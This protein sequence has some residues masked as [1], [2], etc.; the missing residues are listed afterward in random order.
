MDL[1]MELLKIFNEHR[2]YIKEDLFIEPYGIHG[3][4][5]AERVMFLALNIA[6]LEKYDDNDTNI[7]IEASKFHDIG[8]THNGVCLIHGMQ[9]N[10]KIVRHN[11]LEGFSV[12]DENILKYVVHNHCINDKYTKDNIDSFSIKDKQRATRLLM[13]FKDSD[14]LDRVRIGDLDPSYLRTESSKGLIDLAWKLLQV[15][16]PFM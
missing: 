13:A 1:D 3:I 5:H 7:L 9:S 4:A 8:R 11:L 14:G 16:I 15:G 10:K 6:K 12:E 2:N